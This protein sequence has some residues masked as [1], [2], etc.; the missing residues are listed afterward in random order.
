VGCGG[1]FPRG[2]LESNQIVGFLSTCVLLYCLQATSIWGRLS[3][4]KPSQ[5]KTGEDTPWVVPVY[6]LTDGRN[7]TGHDL[8]SCNINL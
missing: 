2:S 6:M 7:R 1:I 3:T 8:T 5:I 4:L